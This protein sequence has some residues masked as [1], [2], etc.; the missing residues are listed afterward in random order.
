MS[1]PLPELKTV[2]EAE[3]EG[4]SCYIE[5]RVEGILVKNVFKKDLSRRDPP[6]PLGRSPCF[7]LYEYFILAYL[8]WA[9]L[10]GNANPPFL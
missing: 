7:C 3:Q 2:S 9:Y 6:C 1:T 4:E 8:G 5:E 10:N